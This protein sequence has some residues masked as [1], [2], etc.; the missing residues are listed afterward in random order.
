MVRSKNLTSRNEIAGE[1]I[2]AD[3]IAAIDNKD[4]VVVARLLGLCESLLGNEGS[5]SVFLERGLSQGKEIIEVV[6]EI[7]S[8]ILKRALDLITKWR[9]ELKPGDIVDVFEIAYSTWYTSKI[10]S[11]V[12]NAIT[13]KYFGFSKNGSAAEFPDIHDP[14]VCVSPALSKVAVPNLRWGA[15]KSAKEGWEFLRSMVPTHLRKSWEIENPM[16]TEAV[17][18]DIDADLVKAEMLDAYYRAG[19]GKKVARQPRVDSSEKAAQQEDGEVDSRH[20]SSQKAK[21]TPKE[22]EDDNDWVCGECGMLE[23]PDG[24]P[25]ALC[26]GPCMRSFHLT[27]LGF[28]SGAELPTIAGAWLCQDCENGTH[29]CFICKQ[30]GKDYVE[31]ARCSAARCGKYYHMKCLQQSGNNANDSSRVHRES[32]VMVAGEVVDIPDPHANDLCFL[33]TEIKMIQKELPPVVAGRVQNSLHG[34]NITDIVHL[35]GEKGL[36]NPTI[37]SQFTNEQIQ[38]ALVVTTKEAKAASKIQTFQFKC[39]CHQCRICYEFYCKNDKKQ[40]ER[41]EL[42]QCIACPISY[43]AN[44]IPPGTRYNSMC[45]LC[46][47]HPEL[48]L[49]AREARTFKGTIGT[50]LEQCMLPEE[51]PVAEDCMDHHFRLPLHIRDSANDSGALPNYKIQ[52][53]L[54]YDLLPRKGAELPVYSGLEGGV[55]SCRDKKCDDECMNRILKFEC[56]VSS[57]RGPSRDDG[58]ADS[59]VNKSGERNSNCCIGPECGNRRFANREWSPIQRFREHAMG[60]GAKAIANIRDGALIIEYVGEVIDDAEMERRMKYQREFTPNDHDFYIMQLD[61]GF[62]VDGKHK[63]NDSRFINHS[64]DPNCELERWVVNGRMRIGIFAIRDIICGEP[65]SYDYQFDTKE[66]NAF[67]CY[68]GTAA[69]RGT[70]APKDKSLRTVKDLSTSQRRALI[71]QGQARENKSLADR[72]IEEWSRSYTSRFLPGDPL[73]SLRDGPHNASFAFACHQTDNKHGV[74]LARNVINAQDWG[75]RRQHMWSVAA[76]AKDSKA[77]R[78]AR[79]RDEVGTEPAKRSKR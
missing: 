53:R 63:G 68:C 51:M 44:C 70:M 40:N 25:L 37:R 18:D 38:E 33:T 45:V 77:Q 26:D 14:I 1:R 66:V 36:S 16:P 55:C 24:S 9:N 76:V 4:V 19:G 31:V 65:L 49:P 5:G 75:K 62:Y 54:S 35:E 11:R 60:W 30:S 69:C 20:R 78:N 23:A 52:N 46:S 73:R 34:N 21:E 42:F 71:R 29:K 6:Q 27:C 47:R 61:N 43:H 39:P 50:I 79:T 7:D 2:A 8:K 15:K 41:G 10:I 17:V 32:A 59:G 57:S 12:G 48:A 64:C 58:G 56:C 13:I 74:F 3:L 28:A 72:Q 67:K 22:G